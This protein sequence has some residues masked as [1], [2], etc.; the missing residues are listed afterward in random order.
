MIL[1]LMARP[2][3]LVAS[4]LFFSGAVNA[5]PQVTLDA[6]L[7]LNNPSGGSVDAAALQSLQEF[8]EDRGYRFAWISPDKAGELNS[9]GRAVVAF[10]RNVGR[11]GLNPRAYAI[12][13]AFRGMDL[14]IAVSTTLMRYSIDVRSG[15]IEPEKDD[16]ELFR[17]R[18]AVDQTGILRNA[19][20]ESE[21]EA[22]LE[23]LS[24]RA[25]EYK[26][27]REALAAY[28]IIADSG[29]WQPVPGIV[30]IKPGYTG[31]DLRPLW[32]RLRIT[33]DI[34]TAL[35]MPASYDGDLAAGVMRFQRRHGLA[36]DGNIGPRT[37]AALNAPV[38][39]RI[40]Q[41]QLNMERWR[42][43]PDDLGET[44]VM[45]N[46]AGSF[47][48]FR[49]LSADPTGVHRRSATGFPILK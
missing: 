12:P 32:E 41:I 6:A 19:A 22:F 2:L 9:Q 37:R 34:D 26:V 15:R 4:I 49:L 28:R 43:L 10:L 23:T 47:A 5:E 3:L 29:G 31:P 25:S 35:P 14:E 16:P 7:L 45:V 38:T 1:R 27:L 36:P 8:Y 46:L 33:G 20:N 18:V 44:H 40:R 30:T 21:T 39:Q 48:K 11:D 17:T 42:W 24:P 13:D